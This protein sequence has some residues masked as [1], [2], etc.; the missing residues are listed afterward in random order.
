MI[1]VLIPVYNFKIK[2][3]VEIIHSQLS[4]LNISFE[5]ICINDAST[6]YVEE[7]KRINKLKNTCFYSL[8]EN[9]G[10]SKIRNLLVQKSVYNWLLFLDADVMPVNSNFIKNYINCIK[11]SSFNVYCGGIIY[12]DKKPVNIKLLRWVYGKHREQ[13]SLKNRLKNSYSNFLGANFLIN[14]T[15]FTK[16]KF[17]ETIVKY[18]YED[19]LFVCDLKSNS[20]SVTH[21]NNSVFHLGLEDNLVFLQ[22]T[23]EA[24]ENLNMLISENTIDSENIKILKTYKLLKRFKV[25]FLF[26]TMY[27]LFRKLFEFNLRSK[28]PSLVIFDIYKLSYFCFLNRK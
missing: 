28:Y 24:I 27:K 22:K 4:N 18:G 12:E 13:V 2:P 16:V 6:I 14:K 25:S 17:N 9:V 23:K 19:V 8:T 1:S 21:I 10:R 5:I 7:N 11:E 20:M 15:V 26:S 3:L